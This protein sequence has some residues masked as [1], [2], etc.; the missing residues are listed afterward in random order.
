[1]EGEIRAIGRNKAVFLTD[2]TLREEALGSPSS[3]GNERSFENGQEDANRN[4]STACTFQLVRLPRRTVDE[5][6]TEHVARRRTCRQPESEEHDRWR[7]AWRGIMGSKQT[8]GSLLSKYP[9]RRVFLFRSECFCAEKP[10]QWGT[11]TGSVAVKAEQTRNQ[12]LLCC[13]CDNESVRQRCTASP[14][15]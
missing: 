8:N 13:K 2:T 14:P 6:L 10:Q 11:N 12:K 3:A 4:K 1:M 5:L 9:P 7:L 15:P